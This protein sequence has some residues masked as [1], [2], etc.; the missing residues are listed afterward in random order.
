MEGDHNVSMLWENIKNRQNVAMI[1]G[2]INSPNMTNE[3]TAYDRNNKL[4]ISKHMLSLVS[5]VGK[6]F[7]KEVMGTK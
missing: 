5:A 1:K 2:L 3:F 6:N 7:A 4:L